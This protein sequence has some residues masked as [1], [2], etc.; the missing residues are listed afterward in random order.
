MDRKD[1]V[2]FSSYIHFE[3]TGDSEVDCDPKMDGYACEIAR[4]GGDDVDDDDA[5]SCSYDV[6]DTC[7]AA[8]LNGYE[9]CGDDDDDEK[10]QDEE[11]DKVYGTS[12]CEDDEMQ[13]EHK[14]S[15][16]S[17]DSG[18]ELVDE[19]EKNRLFWQ[20]CLAS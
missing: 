3:A 9:S 1:P 14:E 19:I 6:S 11:K 5:L 8:E 4:V 17:F 20:A 15:S 12:Y 13:E 10:K 7:N 16:V 2:E 18:Q